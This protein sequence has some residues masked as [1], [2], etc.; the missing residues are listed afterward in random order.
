MAFSGEVVDGEVRKINVAGFPTDVVSFSVAAKDSS[1][2]HVALVFVTGNPGAIEFFVPFLRQVWELSGRCIDVCGIAH[3]GHSAST[4]TD[5][6]VGL[7]EQV[8][9]KVAFLREYY[10]QGTPVILVGHSI[11]AYV[12]LRAIETLS[13]TEL[14]V[15]RFIGLCPVVSRFL[16]SRNGKMIEFLTKYAVLQNFALKTV[17]AASLLPAVILRA[18]ASLG[19]LVMP[20]ADLASRG[21]SADAVLQVVDKRVMQNVLHMA[22][23]EMRLVRGPESLDAVMNALGRSA[24]LVYTP[25]DGWVAP[26]AAEELKK[27]FP[28]CEVSVQSE[29]S[30]S[31]MFSLNSRAVAFMADRTWEHV[32][33]VLD[34]IREQPRSRL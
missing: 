5:A 24:V 22:T 32:R 34:E 27:R 31:H 20:D 23:D 7:Q 15:V 11:G 3:T 9:H 16:Q 17:G 29:R 30:L 4:T 28:Q 12:C 6:S 1:P 19:L 8:D 18:V 25:V 10:S 13:A 33:P 2:S 21:S 14:N 26:G